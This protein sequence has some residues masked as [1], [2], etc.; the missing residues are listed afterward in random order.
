MLQTL[1]DF[2]A[3]PFGEQEPKSNDFEAKYKRL[4]S[5]KKIHME[6]FTE[7]DDCYLI[8]LK[9]GSDTNPNMQYDVIL[10]FFTDNPRVKTNI[11]FRRYYVKFFSNS[12][13]FIYQYAVLYK[14]KGMMIDM[15]ADKMDAIYGDTLP[16]KV[17]PSLRVSYDKS[18]YCACRWM[19]DRKVSAFSKVG[20]LAR[21]KKKPEVFFSDI[22]T[23]DDIKF[24]SSLNKLGTQ[25]EKIAAKE[26]DKDIP[27]KRIRHPGKVVPKAKVVRAATYKASY[28]KTAKRSKTVK[29]VKKR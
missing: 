17:N 25:L 23:F 18:I 1:E 29:T 16:S 6:A 24:S 27:G 12:P 21:R 26:K 2:L 22:Q 15:L 5:S 20:M 13:S 8:H 14:N 3:Q 19:V 11:S 4:A 10:L 28:T 7:V 9:V